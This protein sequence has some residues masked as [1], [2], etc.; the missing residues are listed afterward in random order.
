MNRS[1]FLLSAAAG[2]GGAGLSI[3]GLKSTAYAASGLVQT[4][5][6]A[7]LAYDVDGNATFTAQVVG[8]T[9][10]LSGVRGPFNQS[11]AFESKMDMVIGQPFNLGNGVSITPGSSTYLSSLYPGGQST[12]QDNGDGTATINDS[13]Y[14]TWTGKVYQPKQCNPHTCPPVQPNG[15]IRPYP[16]LY[17]PHGIGPDSFTGCLLAQIANDFACTAEATAFIAALAEAGWVLAAIGPLTLFA[18]GVGAAGCLFATG[19]AIYT[20]THQ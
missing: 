14:G 3:A 11:Y 20:C 2:I 6:Q 17:R 16:A 10:S 1:R 9:F 7:W 4:G 19:V 13:N 8:K 12:G 15:L 18:L 5:P